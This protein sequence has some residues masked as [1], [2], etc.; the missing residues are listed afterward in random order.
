MGA[1]V[2]FKKLWQ[3]YLAG[4]AIRYLAPVVIFGSEIFQSQALKETNSVPWSKSLASVIVDRILELTASLVVIFFGTSFFLL[5]IGLP[6]IKLGLIFA[7]FLFLLTSL[8]AFFYFKSFKRE[9]MAKA[10]GRIFNNKLDDHPLEIEKEIFSFFKIKK[11]TMWRGFF[12]SFLKAG[13]MWLRTWFL[14][15]FLGKSLGALPALSILG[16]YCLVSMIPIT[17][18]FGSHEAIQ[19]FAFNSLGIGAG[20][21]TAFALIVRGVELILSLIGII[22]LFHLGVELLK[23]VLFRKTKKITRIITTHGNK[24]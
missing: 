24:I 12:L 8:V 15:L 10:I 17:A 5:K 14:V 9:S 18:D 7:G 20:T 21:G 16:F 23:N 13:I 22:I 6:P 3:P 19:A 4:F 2:P 1:R 11:K